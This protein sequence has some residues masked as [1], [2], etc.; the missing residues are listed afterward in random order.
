MFR[1]ERAQARLA[2]GAVDV[3]HP[4]AGARA[5]RNRDVAIGIGPVAADGCGVGG[6]GM[7][8]A[9]NRRRLAARHAGKHRQPAGGVIER[10]GEQVAHDDLGRIGICPA[11]KFSSSGSV[12]RIILPGSAHTDPDAVAAQGTDQFG[13]IADLDRGLALALDIGGK[14]IRTAV[15]RAQVQPVGVPAQADD[16]RS[17]LRVGHRR[18]TCERIRSSLARLAVTTFGASD[19]INRS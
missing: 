10:R 19:G 4:E 1:L 11:K 12:T 7:E 16:M 17:D 5:G 2:L 14:A 13:E 3:E 6:R 8:A 15:R 18:K 9:R